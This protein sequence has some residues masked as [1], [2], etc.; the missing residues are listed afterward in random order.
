MDRAANRSFSII[1]LRQ[2]YQPQLQPQTPSNQL[3]TQN[4]T[5][6][7]ALS[8]IANQSQ[9]PRLTQTLV[10]QNTAHG[11]ADVFG[12]KDEQEAINIKEFS[13]LK[14]S[15]YSS[16]QSIQSPTTK[17]ELTK[18][19]FSQIYLAQSKSDLENCMRIV[20]VS[21]LQELCEMKL[22]GN[23]VLMKAAQT[24]N[25]KL[26][27]LL[28]Q[29]VP[30]PQKLALM[31]SDDDNKCTALMFAAVGRAKVVT[32]L[33]SGVPNP[34]QLAVKINNSTTALIYAAL[35]ENVEGIIAMLASVPNPQKLAEKID[36][37]GTSA[38][39]VATFF[40]Y[41]RVITALLSGVPNPQQLAKQIEK[42]GA[43]A[44]VVAASN[45]HVGVITKIFEYVDDA[46]ALIFQ[47]DFIGRNAFFF[48]LNSEHTEA[49]LLLFDKAK[50]KAALLL[51]KNGPDK[52]AAIQMMKPEILDL[53]IKKYNESKE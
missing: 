7:S 13:E 25:T 8:N 18:E 21:S 48:A 27:C 14:I 32:A 2:P 10:S 38:L 41:V 44:L 17:A 16:S 15:G 5:E 4:S 36:N 31:L 3:T 52:K 22:E 33:L 51:D 28:L 46:E 35:H 6:N 49:A 40:S 50:D 9:P 26:T 42:N 11:L 39:K 20:G 24:G 45:G 12:N 1:S 37:N 53:F 34:Q 23:T 29:S 19:I 43:T 30:D 47:E